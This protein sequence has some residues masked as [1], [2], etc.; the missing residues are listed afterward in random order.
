[1]HMYVVPTTTINYTLPLTELL[2]D[3]RKNFQF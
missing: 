2:L 3:D 1:M